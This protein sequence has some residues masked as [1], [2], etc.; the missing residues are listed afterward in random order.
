[1]DVGAT[2]TKWSLLNSDSGGVV[3]G[4]R[5]KTAYPGSPLNL[6][7]AL[8]NRI[9]I[10][11]PDYVV[12]GFPGETRSGVVID[13]ANLPRLLPHGELVPELVVAW[14]RFELQ[15]HLECESGKSIGV[16]NDAELFLRG[17]MRGEGKEIAIT[18]GTGCGFAGAQDGVVQ[19]L[20][21]IGQLDLL[22]G[23]T[24]DAILGEAA[25]RNDEAAW[26]SHIYE[27]VR[28]LCEQY[29]PQVVHLGGGN[30][31]RVPGEVMRVMKPTTVRYRHDVVGLGALQYF[32]E[33]W[34]S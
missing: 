4:G 17:A 18:L 28:G 8:L 22:P 23:R 34:G 27:A 9:A 29:Q 31:G 32:R 15:R 30:A 2:T 19:L 13:G 1:M 5:R 14:Q 12:V 21:D 24:Y 20:P 25:R 16:I 10:T 6:S 3:R 33:R 7:R 26:L 11:N